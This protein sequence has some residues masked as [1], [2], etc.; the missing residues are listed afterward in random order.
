MHYFYQILTAFNKLKIMPEV[1]V[2]LPN[3]DR[4]QQVKD[5][6]RGCTCQLIKAKTAYRVHKLVLD[7]EDNSLECHSLSRVV[8]AG[9]TTLDRECLE[10]LN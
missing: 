2:L 7:R 5:Y 9:T 1:V 10:C 8:V 4:L 6:A 3:T